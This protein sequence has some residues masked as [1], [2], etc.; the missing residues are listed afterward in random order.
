MLVFATANLNQK[1]GDPVMGNR[2]TADI[3]QEDIQKES[4]ALTHPSPAIFEV[5]DQPAAEPTPVSEPPAEPPA[6][7]G[8]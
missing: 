4:M 6:S 7:E 2:E 8:G 5:P 1:G 3:P